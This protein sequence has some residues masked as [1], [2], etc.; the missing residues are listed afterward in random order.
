MLEI[1]RLQEQVR[2]LTIETEHLR[3]YAIE[4]PPSNLNPT[5]PISSN[6][7]DKTPKHTKS[8]RKKLATPSTNEKNKISMRG[9]TCKGTCNSKICGCV[10]KDIVCGESCKCNN[11][12]CKNQVNISSFNT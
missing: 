1:A 12:V 6:N 8:L 3:K 5:A 11:V 4:E 2:L 10:K 7:V 9:C